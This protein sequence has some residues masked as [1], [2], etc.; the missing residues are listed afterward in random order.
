MKKI[1]L[2]L[3]SLVILNACGDKK[4]ATTHPA[5]TEGSYYDFEDKRWYLSLNNRTQCKSSVNNPD[6]N[7]GNYNCPSGQ[8]AA[9]IAG[10]DGSREVNTRTQS[11]FEGGFGWSLT[12][13]TCVSTTGGANC[14]NGNNDILNARDQGRYNSNPVQ[15]ESNNRNYEDNGYRIICI[16]RNDRNLYT[17]NGVVYY[18]YSNASNSSGLSFEENIALVLI[19][20]IAN[21]VVHDII[22]H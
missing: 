2:A 14:H 5:C 19:N 6:F 8:V 18:D 12:T 16:D 15:Y 17:L 11:N 1:I 20:A 10:Q 4:S 7:N 9:R 13:N 3:L 22:H 21:G